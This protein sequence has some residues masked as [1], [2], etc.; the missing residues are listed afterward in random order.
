MSYKNIHECNCEFSY[1]DVE[2]D[3]QDMLKEKYK[4]FENTIHDLNI[5]ISKLE[6]ILKFQLNINNVGIGLKYLDNNMNNQKINKT[7]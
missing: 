5:K 3:I 1:H 6:N 4:F 7:P 2:I